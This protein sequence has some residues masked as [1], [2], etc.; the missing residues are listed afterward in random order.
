MY[1]I[2][3]LPLKELFIISNFGPR[4]YS[5]MVWHNGIDFRATIGTGVFAIADGIVRA[6]KVDGAGLFAGYG[7]YVIIEHN[8]F[9]SLYAHLDSYNLSP[10]QQVKAGEL[11]GFSGNTGDSTGPHLHFEIRLGTYATFWVKC[12][13]DKTIYM[14][15]INPLPLLEKVLERENMTRAKAIDIV[16]SQANLEDKTIGYL[17]DHYRWGDDLV[18]KL[19]RAMI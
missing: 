10:G 6:A 4:I 17:T 7:R 3:H 19:A 9:C 13:S 8:G 15:C 14:Y 5:N 1:R 16:S 12:P 18:V 11:I 2:E